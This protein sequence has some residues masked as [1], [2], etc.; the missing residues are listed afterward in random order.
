MEK[1]GSQLENIILKR[2]LVPY[3]ILVQALLIFRNVSI[4]DYSAFFWFCDFAPLFF[5]IAFYY[6][7]DQLAKG[8]INVGLLAQIVSVAGFFIFIIFGTNIAGMATAFVHTLLQGSMFLLLHLTVPIALFFQR[9]KEPT[10]KSLVYSLI[11]LLLLFLISIIFTSPLDNMN[12]IYSSTIIIG[13]TPP[14]YTPLWI[15]WTFI[16]VIVPT[17]YIQKAVYILTTHKSKRGR[18]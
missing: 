13:F 11:I 1:G 17:Y 16:A 2:W 15:F 10:G 14:Y 18:N 6:K 7:N 12:N 9:K 8:I 5:A 3:F 4:R